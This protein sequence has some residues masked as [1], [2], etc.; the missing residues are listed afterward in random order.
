MRIFYA[1]LASITVIISFS[2]A[3]YFIFDVEPVSQFKQ[4][5]YDLG[6]EELQCG[7]SK[8]IYGEYEVRRINPNFYPGLKAFWILDTINSSDCSRIERAIKESFDDQPLKKYFEVNLEICKDEVE[9]GKR[10]AWNNIQSGPF[11]PEEFYK[12]YYD[13]YLRLFPEG[14]V[15]EELKEY[16]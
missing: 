3:T 2:I 5:C 16:A 6:S 15:F 7:E 12:D 11:V 9:N 8:I 10:S 14:T 4:R 13:N 1:L